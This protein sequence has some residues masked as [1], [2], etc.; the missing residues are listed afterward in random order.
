MINSRFLNNSALSAGAIFVSASRVQLQN[1]QIANN[2]ADGGYG[3]AVYTNSTTSVLVDSC[4]FINNTGMFA[5]LM[6]HS[7]SP[8]LHH[9][10]G[11][12]QV[13]QLD[14]KG[15]AVTIAY[16]IHA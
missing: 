11:K 16:S 2:V 7:N 1:C 12:S 15:L 4:S 9:A 3:G 10:Y 5:K 6:M 14:H 8:R 13:Q